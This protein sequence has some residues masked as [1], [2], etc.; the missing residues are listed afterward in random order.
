[1]NFIIFNGALVVSGFIAVLIFSIG[2]MVLVSP[3]SLFAKSNNPPKMIVFPLM[4]IAGIYQ[5]YF[6]GLWSAFCVAVAIKYTQKPDVTW[7]WLYWVTGFMWCTSLIG[8]LAHKERQG[9]QS[10]DETQG[11]KKG[12]TFYSLI[13]VVAFIVFAFV[14]SFIVLP[15][16]WALKPLDLE[17]YIVSKSPGSEQIEPKSRKSIEAFFEGYE[18]FASANESAQA[19]KTSKDPL[20]DFEKVKTLMN[21]SKEQLS[22]CDTELLNKI[23][24]GWGDVVSNKFVPVI[25]FL[26]SGIQPKGDR[27]DLA[28]GDALMAELDEWLHNNWN[29]I[30]LTL[31]EKYGFEI[32]K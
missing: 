14:P 10:L 3:L 17:S 2:L 1:M 31:N 25:D 24:K 11:I 15:Y 5:I 21:K 7:D 29:K 27:N 4:G 22:E 8:W 23:Y 28:R 19:M 30:L 18:Y 16:G 20:A 32:R 12:T 6:W 26:L 13:A 9:S